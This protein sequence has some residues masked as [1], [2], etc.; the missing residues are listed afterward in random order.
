MHN[1]Y[2]AF[3]YQNKSANGAVQYEVLDV[4][5]FKLTSDEYINHP[6][7]DSTIYFPNRS[8]G[9]GYKEALAS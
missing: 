2:K 1:S 4:C 5:H 8:K 3:I 9:S 7:K 6:N